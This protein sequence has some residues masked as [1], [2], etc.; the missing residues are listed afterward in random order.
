MSRLSIAL[1]L[2][3]AFTLTAAVQAAGPAEGTWTWK[4][5]GR[6]GGG[7]GGAEVEYT[8][9]LKQDG[10]K[11]TGTL[12]GGRGRDGAAPP[13][14]AIEEGTIKD[15]VVAFNVTR[16]RGENKFTIKYN[17]KLEGD[18]ITGSSTSPGRDGAEQKRDWKATRV[19]Q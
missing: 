17:G 12:K 14:I 18:T 5:A 16:T 7:G 2:L 19:K 4:Q 11:L 13:E 1:A 3:V 8:L 6:G 9:T 10:E 15:G